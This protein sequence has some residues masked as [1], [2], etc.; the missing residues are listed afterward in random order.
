MRETAPRLTLILMESTCACINATMTTPLRPEHIPELRQFLLQGFGDPPDSVWFSEAMLRWKYFDDYGM[1]AGPLS[2]ISQQGGQINGHIGLCRR[3]LCASGS[4]REQVPTVHC[5][6]WLGSREHRLIGVRLLRKVFA[7]VE[8]QYA[9]GGSALGKK[10]L[11][12]AGFEQLPPITVYQRILRS[13]YRL[14]DPH[15]SSF[16]K[17][18]R[19]VRDTISARWHRAHRCGQELIVQRTPAFDAEIT[20]VLDNV[21]RPLLFTSRDP[22]LLNYYLRCPGIPFCGWGISD[23]Q[24]LRGFALSNVLREGSIFQGRIVD[25][26]LD[27]REVEH[28]QAAFAALTKELRQQ[29]ADYVTVYASTPWVRQALELN[30][31]S[32]VRETEVWLRDPRR[33]VMRGVPFLLSMLD[34][35]NSI[36]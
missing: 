34:G 22:G 2:Y 10:A 5:I 26:F 19:V 12:A 6:D 7:E 29:S 31:F 16:A 24:R 17:C 25:C 21:P 33:R 35:D 20:G 8:T 23:D 13:V 1:G 32:R 9:I 27:S 36:L 3:L 14:R 4:T 15:A 30:G 11:K 28:W 18:A